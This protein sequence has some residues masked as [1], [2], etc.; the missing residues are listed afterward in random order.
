MVAIKCLDEGIDVPAC[1]TA[2]ILAS[3]RDP[4][5]F[6]QRRGRILRRSPGKT[7]ATIYDFVV[8]LP[9]G[10]HDES[11]YARKLIVSEL[12]R[13]IEFAGLAVNKRVAYD[14]L[15]SILQEYDLEHAI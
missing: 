2:Y 3:S 5:Q 1:S 11:G 13:V 8:V 14:T 6:I 10:S 7:I 15:R 4:R 12:Q 9:P